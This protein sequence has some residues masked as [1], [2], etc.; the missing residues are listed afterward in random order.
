MR[1]DA[2]GKWG[3]IVLHE[4][5]QIN[6]ELNVMGINVSQ[7]ELGESRMVVSGVFMMINY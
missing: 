2:I 3:T 4:F 7:D 6:R 5:P 1:Y